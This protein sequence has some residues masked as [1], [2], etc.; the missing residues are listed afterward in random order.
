MKASGRGLQI[1]DCGRASKCTRGFP[2]R[3]FQEWGFPPFIGTFT[4]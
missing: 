2:L 3:F 1:R 4:P